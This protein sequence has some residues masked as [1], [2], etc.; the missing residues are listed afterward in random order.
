MSI[1]ARFHIGYGDFSLDVDLQLPGRGVT[2]LLGPSGSGKTTLLRC[3]SGLERAPSGVLSVLGEC[4]QR[5]GYFL[6]VHRRPL[7]YVFQEASLFDHLSVAEN[8]DY[9]A[10]RSHGLDA[11]QRKAIV[12]LLGIAHLLGREPGRLSG[13]ERQRVAIA[14]ALFTAPRLLLMDEPLAA[15][16]HARKQEILPYLERLRDELEIP[17]VYVSHALD[18]V[19]RL[20]DHV[21]VMEDGRVLATGSLQEVTSRIDLPLAR[22]DEASVVIRAV[23]SAHDARYDLT[24][25]DF[26]GGCIH[27]GLRE[28]APGT[29]ARVVIHAR[30]V[31][32]ALS[33]STDTT[34]GNSIQAVIEAFAPTTH[35]AHVLVRLRAGETPL[36]AR[37]TRRSRDQ[38]QLHEGQSV[39]AQIKTV[40]LV[41]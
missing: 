12:D 15:L 1:E 9:G 24:Q 17:I 16:D 27:V 32:L 20:A 3:I 8:L 38:L 39:W 19:A 33:P 29:A 5:N 31:S 4:W 11:G 22:Q 14:R 30:D 40:A 36:L 23:V 18:E 2:A 21:V 34:I 25:L 7:G 6:P 35:P 13:G 37:I 10:R 26:P 28:L 41:E